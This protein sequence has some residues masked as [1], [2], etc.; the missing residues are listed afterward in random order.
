VEILDEEASKP[1]GWLDDEPL[2]V[3]DPG[4]FF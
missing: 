1:E 3:A 2:T 4:M